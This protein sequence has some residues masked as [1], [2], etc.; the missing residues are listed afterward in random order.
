MKLE[1]FFIKNFR[2]IQRLE[3]N[4]GDSSLNTFI[5]SISVGKTSVL[6]SLELFWNEAIYDEERESLQD[7]IF[8]SNI[9]QRT[10]KTNIEA[11]WHFVSTN[12][13]IEQIQFDGSI[14]KQFLEE[15]RPTKIVLKLQ[16][17]PATDDKPARFVGWYPREVDGNGFQ[18]GYYWLSEDPYSEYIE[19]FHLD[20][21]SRLLFRF[22]ADFNVNVELYLKKLQEKQRE[23]E[24]IEKLISRVFGEEITIDYID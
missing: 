13:T 20:F 15:K 7:R 24:S 2:S 17:D 3:L 14:I 5:G 22:R 16:F 8:F 10:K 19:Q 23:K 1:K 4:I 9:Q 21:G 18:N 6:R 11:E 12:E